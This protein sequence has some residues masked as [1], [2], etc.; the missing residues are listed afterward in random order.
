MHIAIRIGL[1]TLAVLF[2]LTLGLYAYLRNANLS[3]YESQ[4]EGYVSEK[5]GHKLDVDGLFEL[6]FGPTTFVTAEQVS[7][8]NSS[9]PS[10]G[11]ILNVG[12][13]SVSLDLWSLFGG[14]IV[15]NKLDIQ[16]VKIRLERDA[17]AVANWDNG[18]PKAQSS[19]TQSFDRN[20]VAFR[21]LRIQDVQFDYI[22]ANRSKPLNVLLDYITISPDATNVLDLDMRGTINEI[23]VW[24][25][26]KLGPWTNLIDGKDVTADLNLFLGES[27]LSI[28]GYIANLITLEGIETSVELR[29]PAID[30]VI[31]ALGIPPFAAGEF[32]V[33]GNINAENGGNLVNLEGNLGEITVFASG[34]I[35]AFIRPERAEFDFNLAGP[36]AKYVAE[37]FGIKDVTQAPFQVSGQFNLDGRRYTLSD[38]EAL[39]A[40]GNVEVDGW[41]DLSRPIPDVDVRISSSGPDLSLVG[42]FSGLRGI[43]SE[44]F[45]WHGHVRKVGSSWR[46]DDFTTQIGANQLRV[47]GELDS[48]NAA[49][50]QIDVTASG[51]DISILQEMTG[52]QGL[53]D[54]P[55]DVSVRLTPD[56]AGLRLE[57]GVGVFGDNRVEVDG[58]LGVLDGLT[59]TDFSVRASGPELH[60]VA[61]LTGVPYLPTGPFEFTGRALINGDTLTIQDGSAVVTGINATADGTVGIA[62]DAGEF[63]LQL[64][65]NGPDLA[66]LAD[67]EFIKQFSGE[68]FDVSG[69]IARDATRFELD[70][71]T[72]KVGSLMFAIDGDRRNDGTAFDVRLRAD[73]P[74]ADVLDDLAQLKRLPEGPVVVRGRVQKIRDDLEFSDTEFRIGDYVLSVDGTL[75]NSP[76]SNDSDLRF[77]MSGPEMRALGLPFGYEKLPIK[78]FSLSGE[79][80]G[81]PTGF[82][83]ENMVAKVTE[84]DATAKFTVD[85]RGK[86]EIIG[87]ITSTYIDLESSVL[88]SDE[89]ET[90]DAADVE[91]EFLFSDEPIS[92]SWLDSANIDLDVSAGHAI[93]TRA[94]VHDVH[95]R[96]RLWDSELDIYPFSFRELEG[97]VDGQL[98]LEPAADGYSF[99][100]SLSVENMHIG[101]RA[102]DDHDR[103]SLPPLAGNFVIGGSGRSLHE[104]LASANGKIDFQQGAG[105]MRKTGAGVLFGD[106]VTEVVR[107]LNPL[108]KSQTQTKLE[109]G[110][111]KI[112]IVDG[113]ATIENLALQSD[114]LT[115][116]AS[117]NV[118]FATEKL[119]LSM[120]AKPR[121]G[122]GVSLGAIANSFLKLGGTLKKP[123]ISMDAASSV[124]TTGAAVATGGLSLLARGLW[125]RVSAEADMCEELEA[126]GN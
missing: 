23:P 103:L 113:V 87:V 43:P 120:R 74:N 3:V 9:W 86:P 68:P 51:P 88:Q 111:H 20:L 110:I 66:G 47:S 121:E 5:I 34:N 70:S 108:S 97:S 2:V 48:S 116:I 84:N 38:T 75:S 64:T 73:A 67:I 94:D 12:H 92:N 49:A 6:H 33:T 123:G 25:D 28:D 57:E 24:A 56:P 8:T 16:R 32:E 36:D 52:L 22:D 54:K 61:L 82:A 78:S 21:T 83:I 41:I 99:D 72:A 37:V 101:V 31:D 100:A 109:C 14:P 26:G 59:G 65:A 13:V 50:D 93:L 71:V 76:M 1:W 79:V 77:G 69:R 104:L 4:I 102:S 106:L 89:E 58:V 53:P 46:F 27:S 80:N 118:D 105:V 10:D 85:I 112:D 42:A 81:T 39:F 122:F 96:V 11:E 29:G 62:S 44:A 63:D 125:D 17:N 114:Q 115:V 60:N 107:T 119:D 91:S 19:S 95:V 126:E 124:A 90:E 98:H 117:G 30:R 55:F 18:R 7:I 40:T 45:D 15:I 35:D